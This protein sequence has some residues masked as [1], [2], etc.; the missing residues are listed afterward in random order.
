MDYMAPGI[1]ETPA[2]FFM[3]HNLD[4]QNW[5]SKTGHVHTLV[6]KSFPCLPYA[7]PHLIQIIQATEETCFLLH[8]SLMG[9]PK[10]ALEQTWGS[11]KPMV[12]LVVW[13][14][15]C[16]IIEAFPQDQGRCLS[17]VFLNVLLTSLRN[18]ELI[19]IHGDHENAFH[20]IINSKSD[21]LWNALEVL[22]KAA[23]F[24]TTHSGL[25]WKTSK[26]SLRIILG[27]GP[28]KDEWEKII[29]DLRLLM[30]RLT[31]KFST[32]K[33]LITDLPD[34]V[35]IQL[36]PPSEMLVF[37]DEE[38]QEC[39]NTLHFKNLR[40]DKIA[41]HHSDTL[42][43]LWKSPEYKLW[44]SFKH[45]DSGL[46]FIEG[47]PGSGKST[48]VRYFADNFTPPSDAIV[49]KFFYNTR[50]GEHERDHRNMLRTLLY[51]ILKADESFFIHFQSIYRREGGGRIEWCSKDMKDI[52]RACKT[53]LRP[54]MIYLIIDAMD[55]SACTDRTDIVQF[56]H[57]LSA[58]ALNNR[59]CMVYIFLASRPINELQSSNW[60]ERQVIRLQEKNRGDIERYT[61]NLLQNKD[62]TSVN[63]EVK[64]E[65]EGYILK[66][67][68]GVFIWVCLVLKELAEEVMNDSRRS[69][70]ISFLESLP[71]SLESLYECMLQR[72]TRN[73]GQARI[74]GKRILQ[75]CLFSGRA[76]ALV[77]LKHA[78]AIP[79]L[80]E[81]EEPDYKVWMSEIP[82][83][84][85][86]TLTHCV[87][88]FV[89]V[90]AS[91]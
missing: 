16:Q 61:H 14:F 37:Y 83:D 45:P 34:T 58:P 5:I 72:L 51:Q 25:S 32:V 26:P 64:Q 22:L 23:D 57:V 86:K 12:S 84:I 88:G 87:G 41:V 17:Q 53:H 10:A 60:S 79:G 36:V 73:K 46:L 21:T 67:S 31:S 18:D 76:M 52:L 19:E 89:D 1:E 56:L 27:S 50:D 65:I 55:E 54:R 39:L 28:A 62:F 24:C 7:M 59:E 66:F 70:L 30:K 9:V 74:D 38:R 49:L 91:T 47:K 63:S 4:Y 75:F 90:K 85:S 69:T 13:T 44:I 77:D 78:L 40:Y 35:S 3:Q 15:C 8:F 68:D 6:Y 42:A 80:A 33:L 48:L 11:N 82:G 71:K 81:D 2:F 20:T 29:H 43:W